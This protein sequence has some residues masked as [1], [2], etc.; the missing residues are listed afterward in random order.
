M[1]LKKE[2]IEIKKRLKRL[3]AG[4]TALCSRETIED[5]KIGE[6]FQYYGRN[7]T[8]LNEE[9]LCI[10]DDFDSDFMYCIFDP[11]TNNYGE[12]LVRGYI[13]SARFISRLGINTE[14]INPH[15]END[16]IALLT[17]EEYE[18]YKDL[19][20]DYDT[21]W[22]TRSSAAGTSFH[23]CYVNYNGSM[24]NSNVSITTGVRV[25]F[26]LAPNTPI[27]RKCD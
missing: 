12:S 7:Y 20:N 21:W 16:L 17:K 15:Y 27:T 25:C 5:V 18:R 6:Q 10:I 22:M 8:K 4:N 19:I 13:N 11:I 3:E 9:G 2:I 23:F 1:D 24:H 26:R 14:D